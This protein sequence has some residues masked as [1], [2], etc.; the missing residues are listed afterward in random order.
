MKK[1]SNIAA[2]VK[3]HREKLKLTQAQ[4]ADMAGV[5]IHFI[6]NLEQ[7]LSALKLDKVNKV[8]NMFGH[9]LSA[10]SDFIDPYQIWFNYFN[11]AVKIIKKNKDEF[12][13]FIIEE[14]RDEK[15]EIIAWKLL[16]NLN[17]IEWQKKQDDKLTEIMKHSEIA[18]IKLQ[19][20]EKRQSNHS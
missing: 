9:R 2:F 17:A 20:N 10:T 7:G 18:E 12:F 1:I 4:L 11:K 5:G 8:L 6:R 3:Y 15:S 16:P 14:I 19:K 13:G